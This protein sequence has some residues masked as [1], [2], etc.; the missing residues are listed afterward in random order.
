MK[1]RIAHYT[2]LHPLGEGG[3]GAV[4]AARDERLGR[5]VALKTIK[6]SN[7]HLVARERFQREA[8]A[9]TSVG[10]PNVCQLFE[11]GEDGQDLFITMELLAGESLMARLARGSLP[12]SE[13][14]QVAIDI[15][16]ALNALHDC[17]VI[18]RDVK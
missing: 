17:G 3:M 14:L 10:H 13:A 8:R 12:V 4:Y 6:Q 9:D 16:A 5:V 7:T 1:A 11:L 18:H 2:I 15:L